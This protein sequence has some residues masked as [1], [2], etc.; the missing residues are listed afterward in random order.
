VGVFLLVGLALLLLGRSFLGYPPAWAGALILMIET[1]AMLSIATTLVL[2][3]VGGRPASTGVN[4]TA[5]RQSEEI[6]RC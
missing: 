1:A 5:N 4:A 6:S 2:A 3:F